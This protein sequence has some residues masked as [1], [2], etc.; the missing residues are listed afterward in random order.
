MNI[1]R[2]LMV[3]LFIS[4]LPIVASAGPGNDKDGTQ[5]TASE[6]DCDDTSAT[7]YL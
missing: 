1:L 2:A 6:P 4:T 5:G 3:M 7:E